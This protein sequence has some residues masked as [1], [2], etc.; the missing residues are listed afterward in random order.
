MTF[1][2]REWLGRPFKKGD[3]MIKEAKREPDCKVCLV[4]HDE[5][6]HAATLEVKAWF[7]D[8]VTKNFVN[9][10]EYVLYDDESETVSAA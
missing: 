1:L 7:L 9:E 3:A 10:E 2:R 6:I 5:E 4:P 8:Q